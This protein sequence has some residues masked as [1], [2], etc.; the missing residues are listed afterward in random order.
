MK[1]Y[2]PWEEYTYYSS[3]TY[4]CEPETRLRRVNVN[5]RYDT[6]ELTLGAA[7]ARLLNALEP[8]DKTDHTDEG[9]A[10]E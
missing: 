6:E 4:S 5:D 10:V 8:A 3:H 2:G 7:L 9:E 1:K